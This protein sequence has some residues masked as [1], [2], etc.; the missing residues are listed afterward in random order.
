MDIYWHKPAT[1]QHCRKIVW[2]KWWLWRNS[3]QESHSVWIL[4]W[5]SQW[6]GVVVAS[7]ATC[8]I[9]IHIYYKYTYV[10]RDIHILILRKFRF[11]LSLVK[12]CLPSNSE[13][14]R[15]NYMLVWIALFAW[16]ELNC[17]CDAYFHKNITTRELLYILAANQLESF[18]IQQKFLNNRYTN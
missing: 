2:D 18:R 9:Q 12:N 1:R 4:S 17:A 16:L 8:Q 13:T 6:F 15:L 11:T 7:Y 3:V 14:L 10:E 5:S